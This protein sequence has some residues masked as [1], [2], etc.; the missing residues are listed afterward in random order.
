MSL[1]DYTTKD[2]SIAQACLLETIEP[3]FCETS[4]TQQPARKSGGWREKFGPVTTHSVPIRHAFGSNV[5]EVC[6]CG[7]TSVCAP[8]FPRISGG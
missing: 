8:I 7:A 3:G 4:D 2:R 5:L 1:V 6:A